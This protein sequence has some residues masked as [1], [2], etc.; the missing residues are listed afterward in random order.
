MSSVTTTPYVYFIYWSSTQIGYVG[1]RCAEGCAPSDLWRKYFTSSEHVLSYRNKHG[2]P[3]KLFTIPCRTSN[4]AYNLE[5]L[6]LCKA[7]FVHDRGGTFLNHTQHGGFYTPYLDEH[8]MQCYQELGTVEE[9]WACLDISPYKVTRIL[10][11]RGIERSD[12]KRPAGITI[13]RA[14]RTLLWEE[15]VL[16]Q[17]DEREYDLAR[18]QIRSRR[19]KSNRFRHN[20]CKH[21]MNTLNTRKKYL[22]LIKSTSQ[23]C[24]KETL[25]ALNYMIETQTTSQRALAL[26]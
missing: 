16:L 1:Y 3:D 14:I 15:N 22:D 9:V 8:V 2:E 25:N 21:I 23:I 11:E 7:H 6:L 19:T 18:N 12:R 13:A 10:S 17:V 5:H 24:H 4:Q 26:D 20:T